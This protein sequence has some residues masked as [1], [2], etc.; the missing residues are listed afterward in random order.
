MFIMALFL[1]TKTNWKQHK[2]TSIEDGQIFVVYSYN[3]V[4]L[5]K[6]EWETST[7]NIEN[8]F[9]NIMLS[10][11]SQAQEVNSLLY[12]TI[13]MTFEWVKLTMGNRKQKTEHWGKKDTMELS[14]GAIL[15]SLRWSY[16]RTYVFWNLLSFTLK[17][18]GM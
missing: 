12:E 9:R 2:C 13:T 18:Y 10:E 15:T 7:Y 11:R 4:L 1:I 8:L 3:E 17:I 16:L 6:T 5:R 14:N